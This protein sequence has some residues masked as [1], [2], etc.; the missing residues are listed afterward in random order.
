MSTETI[1]GQGAMQSSPRRG[2]QMRLPVQAPPIDRMRDE[3]SALYNGSGVEPA[4]WG[5]LTAAIPALGR[6]VTPLV[7][8]HTIVGRALRGIFG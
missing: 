2:S 3:S 5:A 1:D 7:P 8:E 4:F 6:A